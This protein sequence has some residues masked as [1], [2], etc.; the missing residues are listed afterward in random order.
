MPRATRCPWCGDDPLYV[1][2]HDGEWGIPVHDDRRLFEMLPLGAPGVINL[3]DPRGEALAKST[4]RP[5]TYAI[6][7][8]ADVTPGP[9]SL[10]RDGLDFDV[11]TRRGAV[12]VRSRLLGRP[13]VSNIL[14]AVATASELDVPLAA[15]EQGLSNLEGVPGRFQVVSDRRDTITVVVDYAHT[16]DALRNLL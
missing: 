9:L 3:D 8:P 15:I 4:A 5:V 10:T 16:D 11:R 13:N 14:A 6:N 2:Y 7:K 1:E 12:H